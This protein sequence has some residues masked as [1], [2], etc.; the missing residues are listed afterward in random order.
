MIDFWIAA[1]LLLLLALAFLLL[2]VL[3]TRRAQA[4]EDR[5]ALNVALYEERLAELDAQRAAGTLSAGQ[6]EAGRAEAAR[7]LLADTEAGEAPRR[8]SLG[9]AVPLAVAL[10]VPLLGYG[11][12]L[13][14]G[15]SD[16]LE[17]ARRFAEQ[18]KSIEE[19][20]ARLEQA[21]KVQPDSAEGWYFLGRTYMAEERPADA[22]AAFEQAARL[23]Q[24]P[25]EIL[26]QWAQ[27]LYFA[28]GKRWSPRMQALTDEALAGEPA[29]VTSLGLLGI[30]AFEE[31]RFADAA[32]YWERLV[33][34]LPEGDPSRA[35]IAGG[36]AR[37]REQAGASQGAAPAAAQVELKVSVALAPELAGKVRP[38]DSVFVFARAVSGPPMP[39]AVE[40]LRVADLPAQVALSD[41]DAMM[42]QLK[43]SNFAEVQL[44]ARISRAGDPT[45]GDW[46]GQLERV[47]ARASGEYVLTIDRA[48]APRGRP[49]EDR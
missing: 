30:V 25:P 39:L 7:E 42:P 22:V 15:A 2:P 5:T 11:L 48:D 21:V 43:L 33:E 28:E 38:D 23:A 35:A 19:M 18:P 6:L 45:A 32:G 31:R 3:R 34:I 37:A 13:H 49:G 26:G 27:A 14:W 24:R 17:L 41:A 36:I 40:R 10:L 44:V 46:V 8:S 1:G 9:R 4:E 12:Y 16:K 20:T 47:S 29:E